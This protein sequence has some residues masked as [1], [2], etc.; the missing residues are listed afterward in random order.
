MAIDC[1]I[2]GQIQPTAVKCR[3][4][5]VN[6]IRKTGTLTRPVAVHKLVAR[7]TSDPE[8]SADRKSNTTRIIAPVARG[9]TS[10]AFS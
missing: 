8:K 4:D 1:R 9:A 3:P 10:I 2:P 6:R 7:A 5:G